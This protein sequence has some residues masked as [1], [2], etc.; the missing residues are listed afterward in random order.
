MGKLARKIITASFFISASNNLSRVVSFFAIMI[1]TRT[2]TLGEYGAIVLVMTINAPI[3]FLSGLGLEGVIISDMAR[4]RGQQMFS[5]IK[6]LLRDY[7]SFKLLAVTLLVM[8][9]WFVKP[10]LV[11]RYGPVV[12]SGF[13]ALVLWIYAGAIY[14]ILDISLNAHEK[15][16]I[17]AVADFLEVCLKLILIVLFWSLKIISIKWVILAYALP[18]LAS[19]AIL[20]FALLKTTA[21]LRP[22]KAAPEPI[23]F[24][25]LLRHG[26]WD[27]ISQSTFDQLDTAVRPWII[28][29]LLGVESVA[30]FSVA[31]SIYS[32]IM[33]VVPIKQIIFPLISRNLDDKEKNMLIAQKTTKYSFWAY[34][35]MGVFAFFLISP[36]THIFFPQYGASI[37]LFRILL[38]RLLV[39]AA[40]YGHNAFFYAYKEQR[41]L[42]FLGFWPIL[43]LFIFL[44]LSIITFGLAG[45]YVEKN[46]SLIILYA[47][48][49]Q[50]LRK[51]H[52]IVTFRF[53]SLI[54]FDSYDR[55]LFNKARAQL[56]MIFSPSK[57]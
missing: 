22:V 28:K 32:S 6:T 36:F 49:E 7:A 11:A 14:T 29:I 39:T 37:L 34:F 13:Y 53:K 19:D 30:I 50:Y 4:F 2:L 10:Y 35:V 52:N 33:G 43:S 3:N 45:V 44:P 48:R 18:K 17:I 9:G 15:F 25:I 41:T 20:F 56:K 23:F 42:F 47:A 26:K 31:R 21:Y 24:R 54:E 51:K 27:T 57:I 16:K 12:D 38:F 8:C 5:Q 55:L 1:I 40:G 46:I